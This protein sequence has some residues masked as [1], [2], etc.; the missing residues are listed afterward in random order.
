[1]KRYSSILL[2]VA[3]LVSIAAGV[4]LA[5]APPATTQAA[6]GTIT[7]TVVDASGKPASGCIVAAQQAAQFIREAL[8][9]TTDDKG[10]FKIENVP[11]GQYNL[12]I[13]TSDT[14]GK[15]TKT[16]NVTAG[17]SAKAGTLK[18]KSS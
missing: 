3:V 5:A 17:K 13:R 4:S 9:V 1:M 15:A 7:G 18:L 2:L 16:V 14:K 10:E 8:T 12:K 6:T 11:E